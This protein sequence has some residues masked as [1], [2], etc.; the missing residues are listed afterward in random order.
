MNSPLCI[1]YLEDD[2]KDAELVQA[3]LEAEGFAC[4]VTRVETQVDFSAS[5]EREG[6]NL[7]LAD[8]TEAFWIRH[9]GTRI[10]AALA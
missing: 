10:D 2:P 6:F 4:H 9:N 3:M 5:L 1:L 7:I 8:N